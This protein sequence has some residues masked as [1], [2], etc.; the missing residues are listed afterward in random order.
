MTAQVETEYMPVMLS[1][2]VISYAG[3]I[4]LCLSAVGLFSILTYWVRTRTREIGVR[5]AMGAQIS[6][7]VR[8][9]VEQGFAMAISGVA[10]GLLLAAASTRFLASWLF[11]LRAM[12][13]SVFAIAALLLLLVAAVAS[14]MPARR[15]AQVDP[16]VALRQE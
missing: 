12:D 2:S 1:R 8:L 11:G 15:A 4:A 13:F 16:M 7:V 10:A 5:M 6:E 14:Y 3:I 9:V